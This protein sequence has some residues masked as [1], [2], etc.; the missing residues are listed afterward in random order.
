F[1]AESTEVTAVIE[2]IV[3]GAA[4]TIEPHDGI[5]TFYSQN[6]SPDNR[7][8]WGCV[9]STNFFPS[10]LH[11]ESGI[12]RSLLTDVI[13]HRERCVKVPFMFVL[14]LHDRFASRPGT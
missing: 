5:V 13:F 11:G 3:A 9:V 4:V 1:R 14:M 10:M 12:V 7:W 6:R 2:G 8:V